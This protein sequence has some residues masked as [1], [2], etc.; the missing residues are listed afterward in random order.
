MSLSL[1]SDASRDWRWVKFCDRWY[2][3]DGYNPPITREADC[4]F[5]LMGLPRPSRPPVIVATGPG[6]VTNP[7]LK[8]RYSF[9]DPSSGRESRL[10]PFS[11]T[12]RADR[13]AVGVSGFLLPPVG[14]SRLR[15]Y[16][17]TLT[18]PD[19]AF[20]VS[21][22]PF[23][24]SVTLD[25]TQDT[26]GWEAPDV[27][28]V[29]PI[30]RLICA[31]DNRLYMA[32]NI[33]RD[34]G[35]QITLTNGR[36]EF[37]FAGAGAPT[38]LAGQ[39]LVGDRIMV[40][41]LDREDAYI[42]E[43]DDVRQRGRLESRWPEAGG[44]YEYT[45]EEPR[46]AVMYS[47]FFEGGAPLPEGWDPRNVLY[48]PCQ[49]NE[50]INGLCG[51][52]GQAV[53]I[54]AVL[55]ERSIYYTST[56][57]EELR[58]AAAEIGT[59]SPGSV[60]RGWKDYLFYVGADAQI[61]AWA[62]STSALVSGENRQRIEDTIDYARIDEVFAVYDPAIGQDYYWLPIDGGG[63]TCHWYDHSIGEAFWWQL[64]VDKAWPIP[65]ENQSRVLV[66]DGSSY[67]LIGPECAYVVGNGAY[68]SRFLDEAPV[69][70]WRVQRVWLR[71]VAATG[72]AITVAILDE[73]GDEVSSA[74]L[75]LDD[76]DVGPIVFRD[77]VNAIGVKL[78]WTAAS[79]PTFALRSVDMEV[80]PC[81]SRH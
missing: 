38:Y 77:R 39:Y 34:Y 45:I 74:A 79:E 30:R 58:K 18:S 48:V 21:E 69:G 51:V 73:C 63:F 17:N 76:C 12:I 9:Y 65:G 15:I 6:S 59:L 50:E 20:F 16:A 37:A 11:S 4:T 80:V 31:I 33:S 46:P 56:R 5:R 54:L 70:S 32:G 35:G 8:L 52:F 7:Y 3:V 1:P 36:R 68:S 49:D 40:G 71:A 53:P 28:G 61:Y 10:S 25:W 23:T 24:S 75:T 14:A 72:D 19:R 13:V 43:W 26:L 62:G 81:Q 27:D 2:G 41:D 78:S 60:H 47:N 22:V 66:K 55:T 57:H 64:D 67:F 42:A 29:P 44:S